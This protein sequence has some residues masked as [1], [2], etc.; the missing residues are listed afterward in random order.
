MR[1]G[2]E[3]DN[4]LYTTVSGLAVWSGYLGV[5]L[6]LAHTVSSVHGGQYWNSEQSAWFFKYLVL[7]SGWFG[8]QF[9]LPMLLNMIVPAQ[10]VVRW[11]IC[12]ELFAKCIGFVTIFFLFSSYFQGEHQKIPRW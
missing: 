7:A 3:L 9:L 4:F 8:M 5:F 1:G 12:I 11:V 2:S 6:R 10:Y